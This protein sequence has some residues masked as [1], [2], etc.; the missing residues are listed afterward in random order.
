MVLRRAA[1]D[2]LVELLKKIQNGRRT[3]WVLAGQT[4]YQGADGDYYLD[5]EE[6][7]GEVEI[8]PYGLAYRFVKHPAWE[9]LRRPFYLPKGVLQPVCFLELKHVDDDEF[10]HWSAH[11]WTTDRKKREWKN[12]HQVQAGEVAGDHFERHPASFLD[13]E[14][15]G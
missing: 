1:K 3:C 14:A 10:S 4:V 8:F 2:P 6:V 11:E 9:R 7:N 5:P 13:T 15:A 12:F